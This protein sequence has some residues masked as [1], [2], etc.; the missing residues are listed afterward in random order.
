MNY[1]NFIE[2]VLQE[3]AEIAKENFGKVTG[4]TKP[5]DNNQ[6]LTEADLVIGKHIVSSIEKHYPT[7]NI[8]DE[9]A[10]TIN[11]KSQ[12]TWVV[13]P[14]DGTS[15]F[16][17]GIPTYGTYIGLLDQS[18]PIAGGINI[19]AQGEIYLAEVGQGAYCNGKKIHVTTE[20]EL[21]HVLVAYGIDAHPEETDFVS[22]EGSLL[23]NIVLNI[24]N[25]RT[26]N[27]AFDGAMV[28]KGAYG[29]WLCRSSKI[30]DNVGLQI[31]IEEAGGKYTD[32]FGHPIDYTHPLTKTTQNY[33]YCAASPILHEQLQNI[34]HSNK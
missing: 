13:D 1:S 2:K 20:K 18:K 9:E 23:M 34:I 8:I 22:T 32:F 15:N 14:I 25:L 5:E 10:G 11:K 29:A 30:W 7:H 26:S 31:I 3:S 33:T 16:A 17:N 24:R 6:V 28:A 27:S 12:F 4:N 19:P 21:K